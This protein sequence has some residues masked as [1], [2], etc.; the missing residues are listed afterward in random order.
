MVVRYGGS[1]ND[2]ITG[3]NAVDTIFGLNGNDRL[4]GLSGNDSLF[5]GSGSDTLFGGEGADT[6]IGGT[7]ND[8]G[9]ILS[10]GADSNSPRVR[11]F[12]EDGADTLFVY[13]TIENLFFFGGEGNDRLWGYVQG[14]VDLD[15]AGGNDNVT[16]FGSMS[17]FAASPGS[18]FDF[19][20][21]GDGAGGG[22]NIP[23]IELLHDAT[24]D[25]TLWVYQT[26]DELTFQGGNDSDS[27]F[28]H[29]HGP[30]TLDMR[31]G[32]DRAT[33]FGEADFDLDLGGGNDV[34]AHF[35]T[36]T[37]LTIDPGSGFD[38]VRLGVGS[39]AGDNIPTVQL[40][41]GST[42]D[43]SLWVYQ[44]T[45]ELIFQGGDDSDSLFGFVQGPASID[46]REG[47]DRVTIFGEADFDLDLGGGNDVIAHFGTVTALTIDPGSGFDFVR[48]GVGSTAGDNIPTVQLLHGST[49]DQSLWVYQTTDELI[50]QGGDD[51]DSLFAAVAGD[52]SLDLNGG[53]DRVSIFGSLTDLT[54]N[55]GSGSEFIRVQT[56]GNDGTD[57]PQ[58][59][60]R[61]E[62]TGDATLWVYQTFN[63]AIFE[64]GHESDSFFG[65]LQGSATLDFRGGSDRA[66]IFGSFT[67]VTIFGDSGSD[68]V[69]L[70]EDGSAVNALA[71]VTVTNSDTG[72]G[73]LLLEDTAGEL[74]FEGGDSNDTVFGALKGDATIIGK[75]GNDRL[76]ANA[77]LTGSA[78][79]F[80]GS[81][82]DRIFGTDGDDTIRP[83]S[84]VD[85]V[86]YG[87]SGN[88]LLLVGSGEAIAGDVL[89][90]GSGVDT[91]GLILTA[92]VPGSATLISVE[93]T[94]TLGTSA[95]DTIVGDNA[96]NTFF[97]L[98]GNDSIS[99]EE[100]N[101]R[102][103]GDAGNDELNG[104][105]NGDRIFGEAGLDRLYGDNGLDR[106]YGGN[107]NDTLRG[108]SG[109]DSVYGGNG[110]DLI[111]VRAIDADANEVADGGGGTDTLRLFT[112]AVL[113]TEVTNVE[114]LWV[115]GGNAAD[116]IT[117]F[118]GNDR[119]NGNG[120]NDTLAGI[121]GDDRVYGDAG[122]D[123]LF[124]GSGVDLLYG[125]N[126]QDRFY[127]G[128]G[129]QEGG[130][131]YDGGAGNDTLI[132][133][134]GVAV[135][136]AGASTSI[137]S[138]SAVGSNGADDIT[139]FSGSDSIS[140]AGGSDDLRGASGGDSLY[141]DNGN[142]QV[143]G[144]DGDDTAEGG[145]GL[146][147]LFGGTGDDLLVGDTAN[148]QLV[149][150]TGSDILFGGQNRDRLNGA[151]GADTAYGGNNND[152]F[153]IDTETDLIFDGVGQGEDVLR[154]N[155]ADY[156]LGTAAEVV[157]ERVNINT[158]A[159]DA[160]MVGNDN[161]DILI[162][163]SFDNILLGRSGDDRLNSRGGT[164]TMTGGSGDDTF[165][166]TSSA[167]VVREFSG[168]GVDLVRAEVDYTLPNG[169]AT[170]F[171]ENLRLQGGFGNLDGAGNG[172]DNTIEGNSGS[173]T[174]RGLTGDD[175]L[176]G[177]QGNDELFGGIGA[178]RFE[179]G[180]GADT[181]RMATGDIAFGGAGMDEFRF[182]AAPLGNNDTGGPIIRDFNGVSANGANGEDKIVFNTGLETGSF[183]YIGGAAF[184]ASGNSEARFAGP[185][186]L[187]VDQD[188]DGTTDQAILIDGVTAANLLT[189]TDFVWL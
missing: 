81:D 52:V 61:H 63:D 51:S 126:G 170:A 99:G 150:G 45:D 95:N 127:V 117:G 80:G 151:S 54:I 91:L 180:A 4:Y 137:E 141:G 67:D 74:Y 36:V 86:V 93:E 102:V 57:L 175:I 125:G 27:F 2:L 10:D 55:S 59:I 21:A 148:D 118:D 56:D 144:Q 22:A 162:G 70:G 48:L 152:T 142:D 184:S 69:R 40:L 167:D 166:V 47:S 16:I 131:S 32:A 79:I 104:G 76:E 34:I 73:T 128:A 120:G 83:G 105:D 163:N 132:V 185:R 53:S 58:V 26:T 89:N 85:T 94:I 130:D 149:G 97:G 124:G 135:P 168:H 129:E 88:D 5:G 41:H 178:D 107:G 139:G 82:T 37:A 179:G 101:D 122:S 11:F 106:L 25:Q 177:G 140:G 157:I 96:E 188:G 116:D 31:D 92:Q 160:K 119:L 19:I 164:N 14:S 153:I 121:S 171:V 13:N 159:G 50:F 60:H 113:P 183:A 9:R 49:G 110:S 172:L 29:I 35:G 65:P 6:L 112:G 84:G 18:G 115:D 136:S 20:R 64:G 43:Q 174:L 24:G 98:S 109:R 1:G 100:S 154:S 158:A 165:V 169:S 114:A 7:G 8:Q 77:S 147:N 186:Q 71:N 123:R 133:A 38:F 39:T 62:D 68:F 156:T 189:A 23:S 176:L 146:D 66:S 3:T 155:A 182:G 33:I 87:Q 108:G 111:L 143:R 15:L 161:S 42:G 134:T 103:Y 173:N 90:G 46:L 138:L 75:D 12:G 78:T 44:T 17:D 72:A 30:A 28:G 145:S 187:Q 181:L